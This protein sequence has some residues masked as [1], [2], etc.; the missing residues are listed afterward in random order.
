MIKLAN[1]IRC[2]RLQRG[3]SQEN[4]ACDLGISITAYSKIERGATNISFLRLKQL[5]K[6][7]GITMTSLVD[8]YE[9]GK[10]NRSEQK[11]ESTFVQVTEQKNTLKGMQSRIME[12]EKNIRILSLAISDMRGHLIH[13]ESQLDDTESL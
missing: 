12:L 13:E 5:A 3:L 9:N 1:Y 2:L 8:Y 11:V 4:I 7:L 10:N 6:C